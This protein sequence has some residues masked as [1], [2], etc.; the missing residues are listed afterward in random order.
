MPEGGIGRRAE[1]AK[2]AQQ[3]GVLRIGDA[4]VGKFI[5]ERTAVGTDRGEEFGVT[6]RDMEGSVAAH[7]NSADTAGMSERRSAIR[8]VDE[9]NEFTDEEI[10]VADAAVAGVDVEA[11]AGVGR[12]DEEF[13]DLVLLPKVLDEIPAAGVDEELFVAAEAVK[14]IENGVAARFGGVVARRKDGAVANI[15]AKDFAGSGAA[16]D[17]AEVCAGRLR[18]REKC[19]YKSEGEKCVCRPAYRLKA[20]M[21]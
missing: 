6:E 14:K 18:E 19:G 17:A 8:T 20:H 3:R 1:G 5:E 11:G 13:A 12:D 2:D 16:F 15:V 9:G 4:N 10:F 7:R 21:K